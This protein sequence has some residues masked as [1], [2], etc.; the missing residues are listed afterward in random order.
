MNIEVTPSKNGRVFA[1]TLCNVVIT[2]IDSNRLSLSETE[3]LVNDVT[4]FLQDVPDYH[5][6]GMKNTGGGL[7]VEV[8]PEDKSEILYKKDFLFAHYEFV[9]DIENDL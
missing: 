1:I 2:E 7:H 3:Q 6:I 4:A 8:L 5:Y 9:T